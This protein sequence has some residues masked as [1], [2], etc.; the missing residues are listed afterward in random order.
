MPFLNSPL[1]LGPRP[2]VLG[3]RSHQ[4]KWHFISINSCQLIYQCISIKCK[5][6]S[7]ITQSGLQLDQNHHWKYPAQNSLIDISQNCTQHRSK[8]SL[9]I[10]C[11]CTTCFI[12]HAAWQDVTL[13]LFPIEHK[14]Q[15]PIIFCHQ[16]SALA[17]KP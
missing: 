2:Q 10:H 8:A 7:Q 14:V 15:P 9:S 5:H 16:P 4:P 6:S 13:R 17:G 11:V 12:L 3:T 1:D